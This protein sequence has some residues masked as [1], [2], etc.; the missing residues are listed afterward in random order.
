MGSKFISGQQEISDCLRVI[1]EGGVNIIIA[2]DMY[3]SLIA[4]CH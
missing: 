3:T 1:T 4:G 2:T